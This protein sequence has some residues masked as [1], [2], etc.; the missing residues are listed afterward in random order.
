MAADKKTSKAAELAGNVTNAGDVAKI[1]SENVIFQSQQGHG[2]AAEYANHQEDIRLGKRAEH[3]GSD[4]ALNGADRRVNG[5][6]IQTKYCDSAS[7]SINACFDGQGN[8]RYVAK[9]KP[10][11]I[12]VPFDQYQDAVE[13]MAEKIRQGKLKNLGVT[14]PAH[15]KKYVR[16]GHLSY[17]QAKNVARFGTVDGLRYDALN[18][19]ELAGSAAS[20]SAAAAYAMAIWQGS[21]KE[22]ALKS[23]CYTGLTVGGTAFI[24]SIATWQIGRTGIEKALRPA[25]DF[26]VE[27]FGPKV[28]KWVARNLGTSSAAGL[29]GAAAT[30]HVSKLLRGNTVTAVVTTVALSAGDISRLFKGRI[31]GS[32]A[33]KNIGTTGASVAGGMAGASVGAAGGAAA[34][35]AIGSFIPG[36][37]TAIGAVAGKWVGG[38]I[39]SFV[40][41]SAAGKATNSVLG[42]FIEDDAK[43]ML[44]IVN[45]VF[46]SLAES[47]LLS[48]AEAKAVIQHFE[49]LN[50]GELLRDMYASVDRCQFANEVLLTPLI[51]A[52]MRRRPKI[53]LPSSEELARG[54]SDIIA[55][56]IEE[57]ARAR[58]SR[59]IKLIMMSAIAGF[60]AYQVSTHFQHRSEE[61][62]NLPPI[63]LAERVET[64]QLAPPAQE[65][66]PVKSV[67][68]TIPSASTVISVDPTT[69]EN[70]LNFLFGDTRTTDPKTNKTYP[71]LFKQ[72]ELSS[73]SKTYKVAIAYNLKGSDVHWGLAAFKRDE[74]GNWKLL[75][76][77][78]DLIYL[79]GNSQ[80]TLPTPDDGIRIISDRERV[81]TMTLK[82]SATLEEKDP[83]FQLYRMELVQLDTSSGQI[84]ALPIAINAFSGRSTVTVTEQDGSNPRGYVV[85]ENHQVHGKTMYYYQENRREFVCRIVYKKDQSVEQD[86]C[87]NSGITLR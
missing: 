34:G 4:N 29:S 81:L 2:V 36:V 47:Y 86:S 82:F 54:V 12:E 69:D 8:W 83:N 17:E 87:S 24:T 28:T 67:T 78:S 66:V 50:L 21:D 10:M 70:V 30:N 31:S 41:G 56:V 53:A 52:E 22:T 3:L 62:K 33:F 85:T 25:S 49:Q 76:G 75:G 51:E 72:Y 39:G 38:A 58:R 44:D 57:E 77:N 43:Q 60:I 27:Q 37:G 68:E 11:Q 16:Q 35:A 65:P 15:A 71:Y 20:I 6:L 61:P 13:V 18:G 26:V 5:V 63:P 64:K 80:K 32:Q 9:N 48:E 14:N 84:T 59:V 79:G 45:D 73:D 23:A 46:T 19:I 74:S 1:Y 40:G 7:G 42:A 55:P